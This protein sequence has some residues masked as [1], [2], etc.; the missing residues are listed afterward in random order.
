MLLQEEIA[1]EI[2]AAERSVA[3]EEEQKL[4]PYGPGAPRATDA[5][6]ITQHLAYQQMADEGVPR[7]LRMLDEENIDKHAEL[8]EA[9]QKVM[10]RALSR[11]PR[12][13]GGLSL[14]L[15]MRRA[16]RARHRRRVSRR[17]RRTSAPTASATTA[18][19][20]R[21]SRRRRV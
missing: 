8:W 12:A 14:F 10:C 4:P 3:M 5:N 9:Q 17:P 1:G 16:A 6:H 7:H 13:H 18:S 19:W 2:A 21:R 11:A 15:P 20:R